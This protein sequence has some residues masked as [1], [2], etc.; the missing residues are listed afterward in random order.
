[1]A[2][3]P[4]SDSD[5]PARDLP[6]SG[7]IGRALAA[8]VLWTAAGAACTGP[9]A[10]ATPSGLDGG[11]IAEIVTRPASFSALMGAGSREAWSALHRNDW[12]A[13]VDLGGPGG[14]RAAGELAMFHGVLADVA[15][16]TWLRYGATWEKRGTMPTTSVFP[17]LV[18]LAAT[19]ARDEAAA[20][21]WSALPGA[22]LQDDRATLHAAL[23]DGT[24]DIAALRTRARDPFVTES[25]P[26]D[27]PGLGATTRIFYDPR[28][29]RSLCQ[30]YAKRAL[31]MAET[32]PSSS[33]LEGRLFSAAVGAPGEEDTLAAL[34]MAFPSASDDAEACREA[35]R[36]LDAVL[37]P[38]K[39]RLGTDAPEDGRALLQDLRLVEGTRARILVREGVTALGADHPRCALAYAEMAMDRQS[40]RSINP[41]N[42]PTLFAVVAA[43][44]L[45][46]G[47]T[48]EALDALEV[49]SDPFPEAIALDETVGDLAV[50]QDLDRAGD[51]REN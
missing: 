1:M 30:A 25:T 22:A 42:S 4:S 6:L 17:R 18:A 14:A 34:G 26:S 41:V 48:R 12:T 47:H 49:L 8:L 11:W 24:G 5:S 3:L 28:V 37:D 32:Y 35:A 43:A 21:H 7:R 16:T 46:I 13:A 20:A 10:P 33:T 44:N 27:V 31:G 51:S 36:A 50:L 45:R 29:H 40:A 2:V 38:W 19:D 39:V 23:R 9:D 15:H